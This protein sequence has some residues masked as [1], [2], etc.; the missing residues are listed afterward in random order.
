MWDVLVFAIPVPAIAVSGRLLKAVHRITPHAQVCS[1][2]RELKDN[3]MA[4]LKP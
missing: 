2:I 3:H 1:C 4:K